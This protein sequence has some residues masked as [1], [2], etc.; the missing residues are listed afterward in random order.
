M[1]N[2]MKGDETATLEC[3]LRE[4]PHSL[5]HSH[6]HTPTMRGEKRKKEK[7]KKEKK[8]KKKTPSL[9]NVGKNCPI[10]ESSNKK[11]TTATAATAATTGGSGDHFL[12]INS[13]ASDD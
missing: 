4:S 8:K 7:K 2:E 3:S 10:W 5:T 6:T 12:S 9:A 1:R 11:Y 13:F